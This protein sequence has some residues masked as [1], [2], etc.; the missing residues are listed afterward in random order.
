LLVKYP[1]GAPSIIE[2][3]LNNSVKVAGE[4]NTEL[5][6]NEF[7]G[8]N[9]WVI[10]GE[11]TETGKPLLANDPHLSLGTPSIWYEMHLQSP[12]QNVSGVIFAGVPGIILGHNESIAWGVTNVGPDVQ[13]LYIEIPNP[14]NPT[15]FKYDGKWED[16]EVR[17]EPIKV[18]NGETIDFEVVVTRHGPVISDY[19]FGEETRDAVFSMQWTALEPTHEFR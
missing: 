12:E 3:N 17:N 13:D 8:S 19:M 4:F 7:N 6:P 9:N 2:A 15:Q 14:E 1:E 16:A 10:S 11:K 5:L 18:K